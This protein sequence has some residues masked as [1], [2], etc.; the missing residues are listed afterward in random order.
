VRIVCPPAY[1][2]LDNEE[3]NP[4]SDPF[5][6]LRL[7]LVV[8]YV[9]RR[10]CLPPVRIVCPPAY[11]ALDQEE[12]SEPVARSAFVRSRMSSDYSCCGI[13]NNHPYVLN[14]PKPTNR[15]A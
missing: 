13:L 11:N 8:L 6:P 1:N 5:F 14:Q 12:S 7:I 3:S 10:T 2:A 9:L 15:A 4:R